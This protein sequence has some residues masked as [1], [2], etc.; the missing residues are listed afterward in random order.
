MFEK[1]VLR[2]SE[3]GPAISAGELAEALLFY[4]NVHLVLD[5][6]SIQS[7]VSTVGTSN[8]LSL[9]RRQNVSAVFFDQMLGTRTETT[10]NDSGYSFVAITFRGTK[11]G[12]IKGRKKRLAHQVE[13]W[14][15][16]PREAKRFADEF[17]RMVPFK[18]FS[19]SSVI[20]G[21]VENAALDDLRDS[22]FV[23]SA[24]RTVVEG[25]N[26]GYE[27]PASFRFD[28]SVDPPNFRI[29]TNLDIAELAAR[30]KRANDVAAHFSVA[31]LVDNILFARADTVLAARY[32]GEFYTAGVTSA[33]IRLHCRELLQRI[34]LDR[35]EMMD[36]NR[37]I[38]PDVPTVRQ[39]VDSG[40][41]SFD[42]FLHLLDR[43][44]RFREWL[45]STNPDR[46]IV[47]QYMRAVRAQGWLS[48]TPVKTIRYMICTVAGLVSPAT[49]AALSAADSLLLDRVLSGW[50]PHH[51]VHG[52]LTPFVDSDA[53]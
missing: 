15:A 33:I 32:G 18:R 31:N 42:E 26:L 52:R 21:G 5:T 10:G 25:L 51:F 1:I 23:R 19:D 38:L 34:G 46:T 30:Y 53:D 49:G 37:I 50:R 9:L 8:F 35:Q 27:L 12:L 14:G 20:D 47:E 43:A 13:R 7:L 45:H 2:R 4:Q 39:V 16:S 17:R 24:I 48:S 41:R 28:I 29:D 6:G 3:G 36:F 22:V 44:E 40:A 11:D